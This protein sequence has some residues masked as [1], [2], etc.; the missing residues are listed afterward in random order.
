M[1]GFGLR[2]QPNLRLLIDPLRGAPSPALPPPPPGYD[3][4]T[5]NGLT[6]PRIEVERLNVTAAEGEMARPF[7]FAG[8]SISARRS[9]L[10]RS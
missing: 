1:L 10:P 9:K 8:C 3:S 5:V 4:R 2:P 7:G 6:T